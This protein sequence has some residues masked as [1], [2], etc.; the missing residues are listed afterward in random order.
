MPPLLLVKVTVAPSV[1]GVFAEALTGAATVPPAV[2]QL[3]IEH[4]F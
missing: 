4:S 3:A 1:A 2:V